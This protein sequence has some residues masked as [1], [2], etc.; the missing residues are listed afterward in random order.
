MKYIKRIRKIR[1]KLKGKLWNINE[2]AGR[3]INE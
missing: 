3:R 2:I 1:R